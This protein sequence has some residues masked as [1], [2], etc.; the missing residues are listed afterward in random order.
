MK[1]VF[2]SSEV[3]PFSKSGGLADV[4]GALPAAL[5]GLGADVTVVTP[6]YAT[7]DRTHLVR[8][9]RGLGVPLGG[10][11][12]H[13]DIWELVTPAGVRILFLDPPGFFER[14]FLYGPPGGEYADNA[15]RFAFLSRGALEVALALGITPDVFHANDWHTGLLPLLLRRQ[16]AWTRIAHAKTVFTIH[17]LDY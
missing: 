6:L 5:V 4:A 12:I 1:V 11:R 9:L 10:D 7:I 8:R 15:F 16:L 3:A 14:P 17:N 2:V 13:A